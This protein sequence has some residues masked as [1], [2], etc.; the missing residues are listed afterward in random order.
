MSH[1]LNIQL[2]TFDFDQM[3]EL[4][5]HVLKALK[6]VGFPLISTR[7]HGHMSVLYQKT[8]GPLC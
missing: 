1:G 6:A 8:T 7:E 2:K 3:I 5:A 4:S